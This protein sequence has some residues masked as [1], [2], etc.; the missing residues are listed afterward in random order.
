MTGK[1]TANDQLTNNMVAQTALANEPSS[2][3]TSRFAKRHGSSAGISGDNQVE[4]P[5]C[6]ATLPAVP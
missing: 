2:P 4:S 6:I 1:N 3:G 5:D